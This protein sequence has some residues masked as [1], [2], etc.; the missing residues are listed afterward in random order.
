MTPTSMRNARRCGRPT[1]R[2]ARSPR[3]GSGLQRPCRS[4]LTKGQ[5]IRILMQANRH[6]VHRRRE[7]KPDVVVAV[8]ASTR[9]ACRS[10][11]ARVD[12]PVRAAAGRQLACPAGHHLGV[13]TV[14]CRNHADSISQNGSGAAASSSVMPTGSAPVASATTTESARGAAG[15]AARF[16][17]AGSGA[18]WRSGPTTRAARGT[19]AADPSPDP[20]QRAHRFRSGRGA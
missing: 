11:R 20:D 17:R 2:G 8:G 16:S 3:H 15:S 12:E 13:I 18:W 19:D 7:R 9:A 1:R 6:V 5:R 14:R 10:G 4:A